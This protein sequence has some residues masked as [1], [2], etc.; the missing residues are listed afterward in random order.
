MINLIGYDLNPDKPPFRLPPCWSLAPKS[1]G[2]LPHLW[3]PTRKIDLPFRDLD[4]P[5]YNDVRDI[6]KHVGN[7]RL[8]RVYRVYWDWDYN[9]LKYFPSWSVWSRP[10]PEILENYLGITA[11]S[12]YDIRED[13]YYWWVRNFDR[14]VLKISPAEQLR[15]LLVWDQ[16]SNLGNALKFLI[17]TLLL[18]VDELII[19]G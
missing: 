15:K 8:G 1:H 18:I 11:N 16:L 13:H 17:P 12:P 2:G 6:F 10:T 7:N 3:D 9:L 5:P 4:I 14:K 19:H